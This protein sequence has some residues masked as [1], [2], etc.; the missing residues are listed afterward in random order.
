MLIG[1][2]GTPSTLM[3]NYEVNREIARQR[4]SNQFIDR[5]GHSQPADLVAWLGAMQAQ[6]FPAAKWALG[7]RMHRNTEAEIDRAFDAG[8]ILRTHVMR[9]TWHFVT[10]ADI[11]WMIE[12]SARRVQQA[13]AHANRS[14]EI[15]PAMCVRATG[16][17]EK[18]LSRGHHLTRAKLGEE[19][20]RAGIVAKG[21][22]LALLT[23]YAELEQI[24]CSGPRQGKAMTYA[25]MG[26]RAPHAVRLSR[27][28]ALAEL[29][30][31]Y[32]R[33]HGPATAR[34]FAWWSGLTSI[35]VKRGLEMI[36]A[37]KEVVDGLTY[38]TVDEKPAGTTQR[39]GV[40]LLPI[41]D[42]YLVAYRDQLAVPRATANRGI[43]PQ[44]L[45][46]DGGVAGTWKAVAKTGD[47]A[48]EVAVERK[49]G[50]AERRALARA[51]TRYGRFR[52][53]QISLVD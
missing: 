16:I 11:R 31:R 23:I 49:L 7:L 8:L 2:N 21:V 19:L 6:D 47:V 48:I 9:P 10:P 3:P 41:Y 37:H 45:I 34:D 44:A 42:E 13:L 28:E 40:H 30:R 4:L 20:A 53:R 14:Y 29:T 1:D 50:D 36:G 27:E 38:W 15:D 52:E 51:V 24:I 18:A 26:T 12:L 39:R 43:L 5:A 25:S 32:L 22:R 17:F 35:D 33:S 46:V